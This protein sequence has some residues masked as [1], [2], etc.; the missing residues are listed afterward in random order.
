MNHLQNAIANTLIIGSS[1]LMGIVSMGDD[2]LAKAYS[3]NDLDTK[4]GEYRNAL[5]EV[6][7]WD[8]ALYIVLNSK[9]DE[10]RVLILEKSFNK[11]DINNFAEVY[12]VI[13]REL[14]RFKDPDSEVL[15][16]NWV[17]APKT[18]DFGKQEE[19][20]LKWFEKHGSFCKDHQDKTTT[21]L[22]LAENLNVSPLTL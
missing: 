16:Y 2:E 20:I 17:C 12:Q 9:G 7:G 14:G 4:R 15:S 21:I 6:R 18:I 13:L 8:L 1:S 10:H 19:E 3:G 5:S 22:R 11:L